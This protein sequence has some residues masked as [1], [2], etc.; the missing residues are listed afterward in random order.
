VGNHELYKYGVAYDT[1]KNFVPAQKG[2]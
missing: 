2:R 1:F